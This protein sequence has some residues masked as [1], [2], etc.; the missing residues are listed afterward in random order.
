MFWVLYQ[1][2]EIISIGRAICFKACSVLW[3][4]PVGSGLVSWVSWV[5]GGPFVSLASGER[6]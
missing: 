6:C 3:F 1:S 5:S 4:D 2:Q